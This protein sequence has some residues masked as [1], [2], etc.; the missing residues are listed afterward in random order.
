MYSLYTTCKTVIWLKVINLHQSTIQ[1]H[2]L[3][4]IL[5]QYIACNRVSLWEERCLIFHYTRMQNHWWN[6][7]TS[8][9]N[10][11]LLTTIKHIKLRCTLLHTKNMFPSFHLKLINPLI[12][13]NPPNL[14]KQYINR[15]TKH[16]NAASECENS[17]KHNCIFGTLQLAMVGS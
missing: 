7:F 5:V 15:Q 3:S 14:T 13:H 12:P 6:Y 10:F 17:H 16:N 4:W 9:N 1:F 11:Q 8:H 2:I